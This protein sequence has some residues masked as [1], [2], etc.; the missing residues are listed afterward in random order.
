M[1][2]LGAPEVK[3][4]ARSDGSQSGT[5]EQ[6]KIQASKKVALRAAKELKEAV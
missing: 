3:K 1:C 4:R 6:I 2:G 5:G